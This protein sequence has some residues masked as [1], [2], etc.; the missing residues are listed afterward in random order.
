MALESVVFVHLEDVEGRIVHDGSVDIS[1][2]GNQIDEGHLD[3]G[4]HTTSSVSWV[5]DGAYHVVTPVN[6]GSQ[7]IG[8]LHL[9]VSMEHMQAELASLEQDLARVG[10]RGA[11]QTISISVIVSLV[12][13]ALGTGTGIY[14]ARNLS[15]PIRELSLLTRRI[16][17]GDY[18]AEIELQRS[19]EIGELASSFRQMTENLKRTTVSTDYLDNILHSMIDALFVVGPDGIIRTANRAA[20]QMVGCE[21]TELVGRRYS[22]L[23]E[24]SQDPDS[25]EEIVEQFSGEATLKN[26]AGMEIPVLVSWSPIEL[27][28]DV[29][30]GAVCVVRDIT[31][32]KKSESE[33][34]AA[35]ERAE[36]AN[37][38]KTEFLANMS[39]ELR[40]PLNAII[41]FSETMRFQIFGPLGTPKYEE[42]AQDIH[43]SGQH[44]LEI[45][46]DLLDMSKIEAGK[47]E[48]NEDWFDLR[49]TADSALRLI[50]AR[51][52]GNEHPVELRVDAEAVLYGDELLVKQ[53]MINLLTNSSKF[54][55]P[56]GQISMRIRALSN[57]GLAI[58]VRDNGIGID[59][60]D[61]PNVME[62]F[63]QIDNTFA[64]AHSGTGLG[65]PLVRAHAEMHGGRL[66]LLSRSGYGTV[67]IIEF[68]AKRTRRRARPEARVNPTALAS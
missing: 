18:G 52:V 46:T 19:D 22:D 10:E 58:A 24:L 51:N 28:D 38:S 68:P 56:D 64:R 57:G 48:L 13:A 27:R 17:A 36:F 63:V 34:L 42:F 65:L 32:L 7:I 53:M 45:I 54:T 37:R 39:H 1:D 67:A 9:G 66:R 29:S 23:V 4:R 62:P 5:T 16:G 59:K 8:Y 44:L 6:I 30:R 26:D 31:E 20:G 11:R 33:L 47:T 2:Y 25:E 14:V 61:I 60:A 43:A 49:A 15:Q 35:K 21:R 55:P 40:T 41:G 50:N 12:L 3:G